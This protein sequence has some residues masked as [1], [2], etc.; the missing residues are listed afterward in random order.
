MR[1]VTMWVTAVLSALILAYSHYL[2]LTG[3][4]G[5]TGDRDSACAAAAAQAT[6]ACQHGGGP[7]ENR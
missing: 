6:L 2:N 3:A 7:D 5:K 1:R 4:V